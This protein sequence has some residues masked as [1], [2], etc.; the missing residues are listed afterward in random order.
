MTPESSRN[1]HDLLEKFE[2]LHQAFIDL[3]SDAADFQQELNLSDST[4]RSQ[5]DALSR[6]LAFC[7]QMHLVLTL[8]R[9][10]LRSLEQRPRSCDPST[11]TDRLDDCIEEWLRNACLGNSNVH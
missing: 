7:D 11:W 6:T 3:N 4:S 9:E 8:M 5:F 1:S 10:D 2:T